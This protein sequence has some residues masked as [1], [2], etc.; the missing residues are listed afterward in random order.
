M[1]GKVVDMGFVFTTLEVAPNQTVLIPNNTFF[2]G[3]FRRTV[4]R[5]THGLDKQLSRTHAV[6]G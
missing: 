2:Q 4:G 1:K 5:V 6:G 3:P